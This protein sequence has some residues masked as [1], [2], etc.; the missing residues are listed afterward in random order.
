M[1]GSREGKEYSE[2]GRP[3]FIPKMRV[4]REIEEREKDAGRGL[5]QRSYKDSPKEGGCISSFQS[6]L[7]PPGEEILFRKAM[8]AGEDRGEGVER[9]LI[10]FLSQRRF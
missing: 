6:L 10:N 2:E 1:S 5:K 3:L 8:R 7:F 9:A 4:R